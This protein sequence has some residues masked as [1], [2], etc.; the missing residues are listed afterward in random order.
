M[1]M[2][3]NEMHGYCPQGNMV[4]KSKKYAYVLC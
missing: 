3:S 2:C 4:Q 1:H